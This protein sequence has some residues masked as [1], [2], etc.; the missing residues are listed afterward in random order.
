MLSRNNE[1][2]LTFQPRE[3]SHCPA[4]KTHSDHYKKKHIHKRK[5]KPAIGCVVIPNN[6]LKIWH[7][8]FGIIIPK[9]TVHRFIAEYIQN[10]QPRLLP[11]NQTSA[12][13]IHC[14]FVVSKAPSPF[15]Y[16][17]IDLSNKIHRCIESPICN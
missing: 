7:R 14:V 6:P 12:P 11:S 10:T 2:F 16:I 3:T 5:Y 4:S 17:A 1:S 13:Q 9:M 15:L 8:Q